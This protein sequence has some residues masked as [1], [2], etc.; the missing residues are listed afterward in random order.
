M[1]DL[2]II[3]VNYKTKELTLK[4]L[5]SIFE[6]IPKIKFEIWLVDNNSSDNSI[7]IIKKDFPQIN[8]IESTENLGFSGGNNL[9]L[10]KAKAK[11]YLLLNSDT[12][13]IDH[14]LDN[15]FKFAENSDFGICSCKLL[16][17]DGT[18]Q[19]NGGELPTMISLFSWLSGIDDVAGKLFKI[20]SYQSRNEDYFRNK[21]RVGWVSGS[22]ML[23]K[24]EVVEKIGFLDDRIFMYGE[25]VEYCWR[26]NKA[27]YKVGWTNQSEIIHLGGASSQTP[28]YNQWMGEFKGLLYI[29]EKFL[30]L[31]AA[32]LLKVSFYIFILAR[33]AGFLVFGKI[34]YS[35]IYAKIFI[36]L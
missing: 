26:A 8:F 15:L 22:V 17:P 11:Y 32:L 1:V 4:C 12:E 20:K 10:R 7:N 5:K 21:K 18:F 29:Y 34:S 14:A 16:N 6:S 36:N 24:D 31:H 25:D 13:I 23:I 28:K 2:A 27:G 33:I 3:I 9:A 35:R 30:G 19:P